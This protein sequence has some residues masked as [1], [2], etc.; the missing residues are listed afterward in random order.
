MT[1]AAACLTGTHDFK[2]FEGA[3]SPQPNTERTIFSAEVSEEADGLIITD[4]RGSGFLRYMVRNMVGA[5]V[6]VGR[7]KLT[8]EDITRIRES[9]DR[10][11]A[12]ATAPAHGLFLVSVD[13]G[14]AD[15]LVSE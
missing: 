14:E 8:P 5:L 7:G 12:P 10:T 4:F 13:Y 3:G 9:R 11:L 15:R 1:E 6:A 2:A